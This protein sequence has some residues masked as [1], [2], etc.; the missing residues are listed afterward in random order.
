MAH[1]MLSTTPEQALTFLYHQHKENQTEGY[2][3]YFIDY[4]FQPRKEME[5]VTYFQLTACH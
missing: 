2:L 4:Q 3:M 1:E 5:A